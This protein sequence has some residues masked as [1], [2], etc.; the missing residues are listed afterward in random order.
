[1]DTHTGLHFYADSQK[2]S[3]AICAA[4]E[5]EIEERFCMHWIIYLMMIQREKLR[6]DT[7]AF[8][9]ILY[10]CLQKS[11]ENM[12]AIIAAMAAKIRALRLRRLRSTRRVSYSESFGDV[13]SQSVPTPPTSRYAG[14][15]FSVRNAA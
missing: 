15:S 10:R 6:A 12:L 5:H 14:T 2:L 8:L 9:E 3:A 11:K 1:M 7:I 13:L 4:F